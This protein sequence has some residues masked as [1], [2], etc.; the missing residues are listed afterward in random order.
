MDVGRRWRI[1]GLKWIRV[2]YEDQPL[3]LSDGDTAWTLT[4]YFKTDEKRQ[5]FLKWLRKARK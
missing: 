3:E 5:D 4:F 1:P 2:F